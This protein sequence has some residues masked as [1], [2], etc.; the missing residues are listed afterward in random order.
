M[1]RN[2]IDAD[3]KK[4]KGK[5][6]VIEGCEGWFLGVECYFGASLFYCRTIS[7]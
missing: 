6:L 5:E 1:C 4:E 2:I 7:C 3:V